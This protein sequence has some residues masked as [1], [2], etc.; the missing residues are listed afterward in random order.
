[1]TWLGATGL[2]RRPLVFVEDHLYHTTEVLEALARARP[3]LLA[4]VTVCA[5]DRS[6]PDTDAAIADWGRRFP[7]VQVLAPA[8]PA[9]RPGVAPL[10]PDA[11][12]DA[13]ALARRLAA[14]LR[15]GGLLVQDVQ[16]ST[17]AFV[18]AD[19]WWESIYIAAT[20]RGL[21][22]D[23]APLVRF[24]SNKRGYAATFGR[25][26]LDAGFDPRDVMDKAAVDDVIV[27][28]VAAATDDA[29]PARLR[30]GDGSHILATD[31]ASR[32][33]VDAAMDLVVWRLGDGAAVSGRLVAEERLALRA[34]S[35]EAASWAA[36]V[37]DHLAGGA[38]LAVQDVGRRV[39]PPE[40]E[41]AELS[42][43]AARHVHALRARLTDAGAIVTAEHRYRLR[44]DL[45]AGLVNP[46]GR[47]DSGMSPD[48]PS[49][50]AGRAA[51]IKV[52]E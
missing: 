8:S 47:A 23:R 14:L 2:E 40:A 20:V 10:A 45:R 7:D 32:R 18:P 36:L 4:Q 27:P 12:R 46:R 25:D 28:T 1:M 19:R 9:M 37:E 33:E 38:G 16:L 24:M 50:P 42:N 41:R 26:L 11:L 34:A 13:P 48:L 52:P 43:V 39:G 44:A 3:D 6:G 31:D 5:L 15:P 51:S 22:A 17:L 30:A 29:F 21:F 35:H 49:P